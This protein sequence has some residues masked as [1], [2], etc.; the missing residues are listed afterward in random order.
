MYECTNGKKFVGRSFGEV[1][2]AFP[3]MPLG[4]MKAVCRVD[5]YVTKKLLNKVFR[6]KGKENDG[7]F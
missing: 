7:L 3:A 6:P 5:S 2:L 4:N 1:D